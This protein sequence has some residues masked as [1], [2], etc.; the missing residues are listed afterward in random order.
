MLLFL[1]VFQYSKVFLQLLFKSYGTYRTIYRYNE[2][3]NDFIDCSR[4]TRYLCKSELKISSIISSVSKPI[5]ISLLSLLECIR[6]FSLLSFDGMKLIFIFSNKFFTFVLDVFT[7]TGTCNLTW[8]VVFKYVVIHFFF[9]KRYDFSEV[10]LETNS[11]IWLIN[12]SYHSCQ[13]FS[14]NVV[15][16]I[17]VS[18]H[19]CWLG[20]VQMCLISV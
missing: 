15:F 16:V 4:L 5:M 13:I 6:H 8:F 7:I 18:F 11:G 1:D 14:T 3:Q 19:L 10:L 9:N 12:Q 2:T 17:S 20:G